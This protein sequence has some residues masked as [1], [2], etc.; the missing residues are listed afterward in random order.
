VYNPDPTKG[1]PVCLSEG[2]TPGENTV[3]TGGL[4]WLLAVAIIAML[5]SIV[6]YRKVVL[7]GKHK[8]HTKEK[9]LK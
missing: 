3:R 4:D 8:L 1:G 7:N 6:Y 5:G 9:K 2:F